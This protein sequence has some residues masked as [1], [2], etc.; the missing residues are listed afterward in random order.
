MG[1][2]RYMI[3]EPANRKGDP[4]MMR[5]PKLD[6]YDFA[7][8]RALQVNGRMPKTALAEAVNLSPTPC[9]ERLKK[10]EQAGFITGRGAGGAAGSGAASSRSTGFKSFIA[11]GA[12]HLARPHCVRRRTSRQSVR[13]D[14]ID[15]A[16]L[17]I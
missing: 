7:I 14:R 2:I 17:T 5:G 10:L 16:S 12:R 6:S 1:C 9:W 3:T 11:A 15:Y 4:R 8:L 13:R